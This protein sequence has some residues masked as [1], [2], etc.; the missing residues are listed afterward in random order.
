MQKRT[1]WTL[2][3]F[4]GLTLIVGCCL[5]LLA[6]G[7]IPQDAQGNFSITLPPRAALLVIAG[8]TTRAAWSTSLFI[9][10]VLVT[11]LG[12]A[13]LSRLLWDR[14]E[15]LCSYLALITSLLGAVLLV[16]FLACKLGVDPLAAQ[17]TLS[18]GTVPDYYEALTRWT[19][20]LFRVYTPLAFLALMLYGAAFVVSRLLPRW[21]G[22]TAI[23]YGLAGLGFFAYAKDV[24]PF[25]H[26]LLPIVMGVL[27]LL[28]RAQAP[29]G[30]R[31]ET[32]PRGAS[33]PV[34]EQAS[35]V[36]G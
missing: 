16:S 11:T 31:P 17:A 12:L 25:V 2:Q 24:P 9:S 15:R 19:T 4:T 18:T 33:P 8:Q 21:L 28:P 13:L 3:R 7:L 20:G 6:A 35:R 14:A 34:P 22:W 30:S 26:Y 5:F 36:P 10:G 23:V 32:S 1:F 29:P 27:L